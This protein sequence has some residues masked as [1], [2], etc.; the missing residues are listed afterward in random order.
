MICV[1]FL[2]AQKNGVLVGFRL[3][4][5][6]GAGV[7]GNDIVCAAVSSAAYM[8]AN[9]IT[10]VLRISADVFVDDRGEMRLDAPLDEAPKCQEILLGFR[11]HLLEL[12]KEYP[13]N[14]KVSDL[15]V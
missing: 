10:E 6:A 8:V 11:L 4:G 5:H 3:K 7:S 13:K 14:L 12:E 2:K 1:N 15:E 9:T